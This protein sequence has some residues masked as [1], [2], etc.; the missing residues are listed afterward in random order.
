MFSL[1][2]AHGKIFDPL[3][4]RF[5]RGQKPVSFGFVSPRRVELQSGARKLIDCEANLRRIF[6]HGIDHA[7]KNQGVLDLLRMR[8][9]HSALIDIRRF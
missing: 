2:A 5:K 6:L 3:D 4:G 9:D 1:L 8:R 7:R